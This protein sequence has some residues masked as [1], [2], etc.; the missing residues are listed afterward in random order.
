MQ[1]RESADWLLRLS[2]IGEARLV[3]TDELIAESMRRGKAA[4]RNLRRGRDLD[5][6]LG[7]NAEETSSADT[8]SNKAK[9]FNPKR[10]FNH[11]A[12]G[13]KAPGASRNQD[14]GKSRRGSAQPRGD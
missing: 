6:E 13:H 12:S 4:E 7:E 9:R 10:K 8:P 11:H 1:P 14:R 2:D 3:L 5:D